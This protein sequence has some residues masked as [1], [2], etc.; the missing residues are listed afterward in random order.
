MAVELLLIAAPGSEGDLART[1]R[2][3]QV[4]TDHRWT[5]RVVG[6][7][8]APSDD[9][10]VAAGGAEVGGVALR[11]ELETGP[12]D[13]FVMALEAGDLCEPDLVFEV[14][15]AVWEQ[16]TVDIVHVDDDLL[17]ADGSVSTPRFRPSWSPDTLLSANYLGRSFAVRRRALAEHASV[18]DVTD[19]DALWWDLL[20]GLDLGDEQVRRIPQVLLHLG[21]RPAA[22]A[23]G[24]L[25][26]EAHLHRRGHAPEQVSVQA[27]AGDTVRVRWIPDAWPSVDIVI[28]TRHNRPLMTAALASLASTD[29]PGLGVRIIDNGGRTPDNEA[30]Y[31]AQ[32]ES[33]G[34]DLQVEWWDEPFNY[35]RVNNVAAAASG[36][37]VLVFM[38]DDAVAV[39][40]D[41]LREVAGWAQQP[42]IG[43]VG[44]QLIDG[45]GNIQHGGVILGLEGFAGHLF[46]GMAPGE[47]SLLGSTRW[48]RDVLSV[49]A[50]CVG[51]RRALFEEIGGFDERFVLCGSDVV[52]GLDTTFLG[53]RNVVLPHVEVR[54]LESATRGSNV[55]AGDFFASIWRYQKHLV[56]GDRYH[57]PN[58]SLLT[59]RPSLR[60]RDEAPAMARASEV[61][62]RPYGVFRQTTDEKEIDWLASICRSDSTLRPSVEAGHATVAGHHDVRTVN[63]FLPDLDSPFYGGVNTAF[64]IA[65]QLA[66]DHGVVN[67][68]VLMAAENEQFFSSALAAAFPRLASSPLAFYDGSV[69]SMEAS[70][71]AAD[72]SIATLWV[73]AYSVAHFTRTARRMYL[74]QDFE[75]MFYP[76]GSL[77]ALTEETY[78]LGLYGLCNTERL[79]D[80]YTDRYGGAGYAF[81]PAVQTDVFHSVGRRPH[82]HDGP[83]RVFLYARPGHWRNCWELAG[84]ALD[85]VKR[86]FGQDVEIVTAGS[87]A[88]PEDLGR[89][90]EH[91]G[92]LDY[93]DTGALYRTCDVGVALTLSEHPSY[94][95]LELLA[96]GTPVVAFDNP[97][98][99]WLLRHEENC[100]RTP[101]TV[102]G[103]AE[104]ISRLVADVD[105]RE[106]LSA[107]GLEDI[108]ARHADWPGALSGIY[109]FLCDPE[110]VRRG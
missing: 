95:P 105:L 96:C 57:S 58:L 81:M 83:T 98:G 46:Q 64:R 82:A 80:I 61:L 84:P 51:V 90:I 65:D 38:N 55:P 28:P 76:A 108:A 42:D 50:A 6:G 47:D 88:R 13:A 56:G 44:L 52:L 26:V 25:L 14:A 92:L 99:D 69:E 59:T 5:A 29:Y 68:F 15:A 86:R 27:A 2:S 109:D 107:R 7:A 30:W 66:A 60:P 106:R 23:D 62:G 89:G 93:R 71:P 53:L 100:V 101:R 22:P 45:D 67:R 20:L 9:P 77:Y 36:A 18:A 103:L 40:A 87:W 54:H 102:D 39:D 41:W 1:I 78:R 43:L 33:L 73:T 48:Y 74:I 37:D 94:L 19:T 85:L 75:P 110:A 32:A 70:V 72:V 8:A 63:W 35:S 11:A 24:N 3:L 34:L 16:P 31:Q 49:T 91:R 10:R 79:R 12:P 97:A 17:A 4:Q 21:R 104:G